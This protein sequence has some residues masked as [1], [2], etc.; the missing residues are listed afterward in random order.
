MVQKA[1]EM[2]VSPAA[3]GLDPH[4]QVTRI[5]LERMRANAI[6]AAEQCGILSLPEIGEP[7]ALSHLIAQYEPGRWLVFCDEDADAANPVAALQTVPPQ[8]PLAVLIGPE[9]G[10]AAGRARGAAQAAEGGA[11]IARPAHSARRHGRGGG[12]GRG[13][14]GTRRLALE[15]DPETRKS[16]VASRNPFGGRSKVGKDRL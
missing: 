10:F 8:S 4:G 3:A 7:A 1:V 2:G 14:V 15:H 16:V 9:G 6:E 5:N 12:A 11:A 13:S